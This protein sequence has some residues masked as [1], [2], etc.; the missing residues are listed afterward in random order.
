MTDQT[1]SDSLHKQA[2]LRIKQMILSR[3]LA[4]GE[5]VMERLLGRQLEMSRGPI[6][7]ALVE[8]EKEDLIRR[9]GHGIRIVTQVTLNDL[10]EVYEVRE[11][12]EGSAARLLASRISDAELEQL[13]QLAE[14]LDGPEHPDDDEITF[15]ESI[16]KNC[17]NSLLVRIA[18]SAHVHMRMLQIRDALITRGMIRDQWGFDVEISHEQIVD[19][20]ERRDPDAA[21]QAAKKHMRDNR[22]VLLRCIR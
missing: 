8:L 10:V 21:E 7:E 15:H 5:P 18:E 12:L 6:R 11:M 3:E 4:P 17:G 13:R 16:I 9:V 22:D 1:L 14:K 2:Y 20:L 19:A